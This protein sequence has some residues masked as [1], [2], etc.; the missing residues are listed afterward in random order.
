MASVWKPAKACHVKIIILLC[1]QH[2]QTHLILVAIDHMDYHPSQ[3]PTNAT[4]IKRSLIYETYGYYHSPTKSLTPSEEEF[5]KAFMKA[6]FKINLSLHRNLSHLKRVGIFTWI[7]GWGV[8]SN[9]KKY[10]QD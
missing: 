4:R 9:A 5:L 3:A 8:Y 10:S 6:L 1:F 2:F 7:L